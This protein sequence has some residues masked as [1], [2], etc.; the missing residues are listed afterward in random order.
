MSE[1]RKRIREAIL[2]PGS[3]EGPQGDRTV[4][5][6]QADAVLTALKPHDAVADAV[7][8]ICYFANQEDADGFKAA[9]EAAVPT[10]RAFPV[11]G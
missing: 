5:E 1:L 4:T 8:V 6:W 3:T 7:P 2:L 10:M 11:K 9:V